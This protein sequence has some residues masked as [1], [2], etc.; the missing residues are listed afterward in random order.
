MSNTLHLIHFLRVIF[1]NEPQILQWF[2]IGRVG[3]GKRNE[4]Q[5]QFKGNIYAK[6]GYYA[7]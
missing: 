6:A 4:E 3:N 7:C 5:K 1:N 2:N